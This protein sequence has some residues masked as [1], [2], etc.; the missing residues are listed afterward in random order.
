MADYVNHFLREVLQFTGLLQF[1]G[2]PGINDTYQV[3][4]VIV[5]RSADSALRPSHC[6][7][8]KN[9]FILP[10]KH[11][12]LAVFIQT[13]L[14]VFIQAFEGIFDSRKI[15]NTVFNSFQESKHR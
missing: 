6:E 8:R 1:T 14:I 2:F 7:T 12:E 4:T 11:I 15:G 3:Y 10:V 5:G 9:G 13:T